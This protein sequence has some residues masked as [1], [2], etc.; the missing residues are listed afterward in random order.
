MVI[1]S[2]QQRHIVGSYE[3]ASIECRSKKSGGM[4]MRQIY[5]YFCFYLHFVSMG[6]CLL[7]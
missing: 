6:I 3:C 5:E 2:L 1:N 4:L 7:S